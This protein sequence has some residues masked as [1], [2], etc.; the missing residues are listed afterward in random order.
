MYMCT[1]SCQK[2]VLPKSA[3]SGCTSTTFPSTILK[4]PGWFIQPF[5]AITINDP[6]TPA[7]T[8]GIPLAKC[9]RGESRSQP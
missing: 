4:P 6:A 9:Q 3:D 7:S 2:Y 8:T 5:T 1:N